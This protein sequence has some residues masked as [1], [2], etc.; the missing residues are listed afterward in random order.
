[1]SKSTTMPE[2]CLAYRNLV[3]YIEPSYQDPKIHQMQAMCR[4]ELENISNQAPKRPAIEMSIDGKVNI[5]YCPSME[6][7]KLEEIVT[8][9]RQDPYPDPFKIKDTLY[10]QIG[11]RMPLE[12]KCHYSLLEISNT[13]KSAKQVPLPPLTT[14]DSPFD[15][16]PQ[17]GR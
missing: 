1:M 7:S 10:P 3:S 8:V 2:S 4:T 17:S 9:L 12:S 6:T 16:R 11:L 5:P 13:T 14:V 15:V